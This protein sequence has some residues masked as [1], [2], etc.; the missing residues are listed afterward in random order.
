MGTTLQSNR[1]THMPFL[2]RHENQLELVCCISDETSRRV[3]QYSRA[4]TTRVWKLY[5]MPFRDGIGILAEA[6]RI[7]TGLGE[8]EI[9]CSPCVSRDG[10]QLYLSFIATAR[11]GTGPLTHYL[12]RANGSD[13]DQLSRPVR[14]GTEPCYAGFSRP[15][16]TAMASGNDGLIRFDG[17]TR[18][19]L[20]T[21]FDQISRIS[22]CFDQPSR[23]LVTG[24]SKSDRQLSGPSALHSTVVYDLEQ[25][26]V[27]GELELDGRPLYKPTLCTGVV[28]YAGERAH[29]REGWNLRSTTRHATKSSDVRARV[30]AK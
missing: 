3:P 15:D 27:V 21:D 13:L 1:L 29:V 28:A 11:H 10:G 30:I 24:I 25:R 20:D 5:W 26:R 18:F 16:L 23:L 19:R 9:E 22:F 7:Q 2:Y 14:I 6:Q 12:Y 8:N 17:N 4:G